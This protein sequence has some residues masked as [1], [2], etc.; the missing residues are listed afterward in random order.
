MEQFELKA[1]KRTII[2]KRV[3]GL[4][5]EGLVPAVLYGPKTEPIPIQCDRREL[6]RVLARAG[7]TNMISLRIGDGG[8]LKVALAREVQR[9]AITNELYHVD[10]YQVVMTEKVRADVNIIFTGQPP[11]VQQ[12]VAMLLQGVDSVEIEGLPG[13]LIH[14]IEVDLSTLEVDDAICV[15]DL[16]VPENI[17]IL[18][19]G[20]E[21]VARVQRLRAAEEEVEEEVEVE[22]A[23]EEVEVIA[24]GRVVEAEEVKEAKEVKEKAEPAGEAE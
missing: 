12:N 4:R 21:V 24:K 1:E 10:F 17:T 11:A 22:M 3:K 6:Q 16:Q 20:D 18:T 9:D 13:D 8:R 7:G 14:S 15:R 5:R 23:P 2:G 19:D